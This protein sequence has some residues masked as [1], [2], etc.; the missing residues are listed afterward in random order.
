MISVLDSLVHI[1]I[2]FYCSVSVP[3]S[4][5]LTSNL[6][7]IHACTQTNNVCKMLS[8]LLLL[9]QSHKKAFLMLIKCTALSSSFLLSIIL[10]NG[11]E[12]LYQVAPTIVQKKQ[13]ILFLKTTRK[14]TFLQPSIFLIGNTISFSH[15]TAQI[16]YT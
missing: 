1:Y 5:R 10:R 14:T 7:Y 3:W 9:K 6:H 16:F 8:T 2:F 13:Q 4:D 12:G 15:N 11:N